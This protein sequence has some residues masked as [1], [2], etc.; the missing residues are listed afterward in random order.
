MLIMAGAAVAGVGLAGAPTALADGPDTSSAVVAEINSADWP[1]LEEGQVTWE[2]TIVKFLLA[3]L[4]YYGDTHADEEFDNELTE[5]VTAYQDDSGLEATGRVDSNTW[6]DLTGDFGI[7]RQGDEGLK[8]KAVQ[9]AL[10]EGHGYDLA[11]DGIFGP[12]TAKAVRAFQEGAEIDPDGEVGP[13][14]FKSLL[15]YKA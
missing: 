14:T 15:T 11:V 3:D 13:I 9:Y 5:A 7:V 12:A 8:V 6:D 10:A 1:E 2:V 4:G